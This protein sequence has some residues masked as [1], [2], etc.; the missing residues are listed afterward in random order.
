LKIREAIL[1][2]N[3]VVIL[4]AGHLLMSHLIDE[5]LIF[6]FYKV[7]WK[8][9]QKDELETGLDTVTWYLYHTKNLFQNYR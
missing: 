6:C 7:R 8:K 3:G 5:F 1:F 9:N 2:A 4:E